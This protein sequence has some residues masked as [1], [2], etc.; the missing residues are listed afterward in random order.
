MTTQAETK[1]IVC[2]V[3]INGFK[4]FFTSTSLVPAARLYASLLRLDYRRAYLKS[5]PS[6]E[7]DSRRKEF[8]GPNEVHLIKIKGY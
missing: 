6:P 8:A 5:I 1:A 3:G 7:I 4:P 2:A